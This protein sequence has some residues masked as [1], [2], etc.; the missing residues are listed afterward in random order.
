MRLDR[1]KTLRMG[2]S[3][4][5]FAL[6]AF[7]FLDFWYF[8]AQS[9]AEELLYLQFVPSLLKFMKTA[10]FGATGFI[11]VLI[12]TFLFG[13]VYCS[14]ICPL[15]T[16][17]DAI[18]ALFRKKR[19][20]Y[21]FQYT[22]PHNLLRYTILALTVIFLVAGSGFL[23]NLLDP[24]STFG[25]MV[26]NLLRPAAL[27]V[28]NTAAIILE[29]LGVHSLYRI[30][31]SVIAP[32]SVGVSIGMLM[33]VSLLSARHGRL[34]CNTVCPVGALLGIVSKY[35]MLRIQINPDACKKCKLCENVCKAGC[36]DIQQKT[37]DVSRCVDCYNCFA[38]CRKNALR[39]E[40]QWNRQ[41]NR[42][43]PESGRRRFMVG[44]A[45]G[46][47]G[48]AVDAFGQ[49]TTIQSQPTTIPEQITT[50]VSPPGSVS[51]AHFTSTCT[52]CHL[53]VSACPSR[54]LVPSFLQY[55]LSGMMQPRMDYHAG[56]CNYDCTVCLDVCPSGA[57]LSL[58]PEEKK[59][60]QLG[61]AKFIKEN[62]VVYTD[63]TNCG[64]CSEH[65]PTKAVN[66]VPYLN[67]ATKQ[68]VIPKVNPDICIGCGGCEYACPTKPY[69]AIYVEGNPVHKIAQ[70]PVTK[71]IDQKVDPHEDFPF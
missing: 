18:G 32:I 3:A 50:P 5:F 61:V 65:C 55:G 40:N 26:S 24:F 56:H 6:I 63:N 46:V 8:G 10:A 42:V 34:Y 21:S 43:Q 36:I 33:L 44:M 17:Q 51:V 70:K 14:T 25:R 2:V 35:S 68:L 9:M 28:N 58:T 57:I 54:V 39:F 37:V 67:T 7:L 13:R 53:C 19:K 59:L 29:K 4:V 52:A 20:H 60:T 38:V 47:A 22:A 11:V 62:C 48:M 69:K 23:L 1:L 49:T 64:A 15:G 30:Q 71:K 41:S 31:W 12:L 27:A 66:M 16:L 45:M